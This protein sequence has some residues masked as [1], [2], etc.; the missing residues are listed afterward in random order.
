MERR[1]TTSICLRAKETSVS[2]NLI[3]QTTANRLRNAKRPSWSSFLEWKRPDEDILKVKV[4][5]LQWQKRQKDLQRQRECSTII[6]KSKLRWSVKG[7]RELSVMIRILD[8]LELEKSSCCWRAK[9]TEADSRNGWIRLS[10][11]LEQ[12]NYHIYYL[13]V[14]NWF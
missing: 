5:S 7:T 14:F 4:S 12:Y 1:R 2:D 11:I 10:R 6:W 8:C 3:I 9:E 13:I